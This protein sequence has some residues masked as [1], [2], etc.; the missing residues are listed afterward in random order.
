MQFDIGKLARP[1]D[2]H[3]EIE[4]SLGCL[5]LGDVDVEVADR[6]GF[7]LPLRGLVAIH[8]R[9]AAVQ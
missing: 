8:I 2:G 5:H 3:E 1:V 7:E 4:L 9:Q 6:I